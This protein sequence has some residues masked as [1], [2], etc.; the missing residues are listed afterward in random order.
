MNLFLKSI[1][2]NYCNFSGRARR[3]ELWVFLLFTI[4][5]SLGMNFLDVELGTYI[6]DDTSQEGGGLFSS[7]FVLLMIIPFLALVVRR[8]HDMGH[9]GWWALTLLIPYYIGLILLLII[10]LIGGQKKDNQWGSPPGDND[11]LRQGRRAD[12]RHSGL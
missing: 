2:T 7:I 3:A 8:F 10:G 11:K 6:I 12:S 9:S 1:T 4:P 5:I